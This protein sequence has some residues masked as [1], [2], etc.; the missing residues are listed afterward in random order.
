MEVTELFYATLGSSE[1]AQQGGPPPSF[2]QVD[3]ILKKVFM[4]KHI[5][6]IF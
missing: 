4:L 5:L 3:I 1:A 2:L 6:H